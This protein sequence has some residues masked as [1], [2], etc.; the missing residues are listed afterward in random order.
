MAESASP[1]FS[2]PKPGD[3]LR[4]RAD[5]LFALG[6]VIAITVLI[7]PMPSWLLDMGLAISFTLAV[8]VLMTALFIDKPLDFSSFP[9]ILLISTMIRLALNMASTRLILSQGHEGTDAAG[10][11]IQAFGNFLMQGNTVIGIIVFAILVIVNFMVITKGSGRIAEVS[12]R[13][14]LDAMPGKQMAI[15]ADLSA[16]IITDIE[17][18]QRRK[19]LEDESTFFGAM[20]GAA[21]FVRGD[22]V[23]GLLITLINVI[24]GIIIGMV[25]NNVEFA[26]AG[27]TYTFLT[28]GDG[29]VT[30]IPALI[31]SVAA[32]MLVTKAGSRGS[33]DKAVFAQLGAYPAALGMSS[34]LMG[35]LALLPGIPMVP[36]LLLSVCMGSAS[37]FIKKGAKAEAAAAKP[38]A[39]KALPGASAKGTE[40]AGEETPQ[41]A[42]ISDILYLDSLKVEIG[43]ALLGMVNGKAA[44][45]TLPDQIKSLRNQLAA[46]MGFIVPSVRIQ[47]NLQL[48]SN[49]YRIMLKEIQVGDGVI[50][51]DQWMVM[52]PSGEKIDLSGEPT[53]EPAFGLPAMWISEKLKEEADFKGYTT[54]EPSTVLITHLT[55]VIK[56]NMPDLLSYAETQKLLDQLP[57]EHKKLADDVI[58]DQISLGGLQRVLQNLLG[59]RVSIRDLPLILEG[60]ADATDSTRNIM[61]ITE[62]VRS[63]MSRSISESFI[64]EK[65]YV[66]IVSLSSEWEQEFM[67]ALV[68][69]AEMRTLALAPTKLQEFMKRIKMVFERQMAMGAFPVLLTSPAIR[70]YVRSVVERFR[71]MTPVLSQNEISPKVKIQTLGQV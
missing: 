40:Q 47:D 11:V 24:G 33:I 58:P 37:Y 34:F 69:D 7:L 3:I 51:P 70:P 28:I 26:E 50:K 20:D 54:V 22:A 27:R 36:F 38:P 4:G 39:T 67:N 32:G 63:R 13:F 68:G 15:D 45:A 16:G 10:K 56:D 29:L 19:D 25:Y 17:A 49:N 53:V 1:K 43:Y 18:K 48:S 55:E 57:E 5:I 66:P 8:L 31:I 46:E 2:L 71:P 35:G 52:N 59:E 61:L 23:A 44:G 30:Q 65:G 6:L 9:T 14:S 60:I 62:H 41:D 42:P 12:A 21:K 64:N